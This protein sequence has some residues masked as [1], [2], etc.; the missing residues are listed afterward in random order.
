[1]KLLSFQPFSLYENGGGNRIL[2]RLYQDREQQITSLAVTGFASTPKTGQI[3]EIIITAAPATRRWMR[4]YFRDSIIWLREKAFRFWTI[5]RIRK[6]AANMPF[7]V[8]H[9]VN[10]GPFSA[11]LNDDGFLNGKPLW[12]SFHDHFSTTCGSFTDADKLW[13]KADRRLVISKELGNEYQ[14]LFGNMPYTVI[15]DGVETTEL[16]TPSAAKQSPV[17]IYFAG[18]LHIE[19]IKLFKVLADALDLLTKQDLTFKLVLRATQKMPFLNNRLFEVEYREMT[20]N[21]DELNNELNSA[22]I[23]YLPIKF[24]TPNFYLYSL[25]TKMIGY[26]GG[27]GAI[28][29]HGPGDSAACNMLQRANAA[30]C[31]NTLNTDDLVKSIIDLINNKSSISYNAKILAQESFN[32]TIMQQRFWQL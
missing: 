29:Y 6:I 7:D 3:K 23:L 31:C 30:V 32:M 10:H 13:N 27:A 24:T 1:M 20:L 17:I 9:V 12:V 28:L 11:A 18:L 4:W 22:S 21:N 15:T 19:Y 25:S 2:R 5:N 26:L 8:L 16:S 14:K